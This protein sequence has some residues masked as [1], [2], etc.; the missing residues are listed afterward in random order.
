L[1]LEYFNRLAKRFCNSVKFTFLEFNLQRLAAICAL[2]AVDE[3]EVFPA[4]G[5]DK[6]IDVIWSVLL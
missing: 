1:F 4:Q 5:L 2:R 3:S 6:A